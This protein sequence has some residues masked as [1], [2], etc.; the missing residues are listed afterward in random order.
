MTA[1]KLNNIINPKKS[2]HAKII[3]STK[4]SDLY[5]QPKGMSEILDNSSAISDE[6]SETE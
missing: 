3:T 5:T 4:Q 1:A 6:N 2:D